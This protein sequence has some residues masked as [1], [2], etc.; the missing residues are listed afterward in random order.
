VGQEDGGGGDEPSD[1]QVGLQ[2]DQQARGKTGEDADKRA[3]ELRSG[4]GW[5]A[6]RIACGVRLAG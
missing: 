5:G 1:G 6:D 2:A 3:A 4:P